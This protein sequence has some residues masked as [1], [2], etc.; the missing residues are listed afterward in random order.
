MT[1]FGQ[2]E[3]IAG[4]DFYFKV[5][6]RSVNHRFLDVAVRLPRELQ[7][8]EERVRCVVQQLAGRGRIEVAVFSRQSNPEKLTVSLNR[9]LAKS[10]YLALCELNEVC[11]TDELLGAAL[12]SRFPE[13]L[14]LEN[15]TPDLEAVWNV[16]APVLD[17]ALTELVEQRSAE[18]ER[19]AADIRQ[20]LSLA[21]TYLTELAGRAPAVAEEYRLKLTE[22]LRG[23]LGGSGLDETR[24]F[25]EAALFADRS[26]ITEEIVRMQSHLD[27]F[28]QTLALKEPVGKKLD[29]LAQ[30]LFREI[31]TV[32]AKAGDFEVV[33]L[34]VEIKAELEKIR[35]Q[36]HNIE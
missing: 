22:R 25:A 20:R 6:V 31:N 27:F 13:V 14:S 34:V 33:R 16:L 21:E 12:L 36:V 32:G 17:R 3:S 26:N 1:G 35:E 2:A 23:Y 18:G 15:I 5:E 4:E 9:P 7:A 10:Y 24:L 11:G 8:L 19:L 28:R 29:F 30:E